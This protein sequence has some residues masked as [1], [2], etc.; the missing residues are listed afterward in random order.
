ML[1]KSIFKKSN[2]VVS[3]S[4]SQALG[5][6][7]LEQRVLLSSVQ[8]FATGETGDEVFQLKVAGEVVG[9]YEIGIYEVFDYQS[10]EAISADDVEVVFIN[11]SWDEATGYDRNLFV[12]KIR[13]DGVSYETENPSVYSTGYIDN[14]VLLD[15]GYLETETLNVNGAFTYSAAGATSRDFGTKI[16]V[17]VLGQEGGEHFHLY[18]DGIEVGQYN[19]T[20]YQTDYY[21][22]SPEEVSIEQIQ[23]EFMN[24]L[25]DPENGID[26]NLTVL[27]VQ[28]TDYATGEST[29]YFADDLYVFSTGV[30]LEGSGITPGFGLGNTLHA[31]GIFD[32]G[33]SLPVI[34]DPSETP[35]TGSSTTD[36]VE[37]TV[38]VESQ[39]TAESTEEGNSE[40]PTLANSQIL[41]ETL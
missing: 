24:D 30:Y 35:E 15:P 25:Y 3:R 40:L 1:R 19:A 4:N 6:E 7:S 5:V 2:E 39:T 17:D 22:N 32:F 38:V 14:G 9:E 41:I 37:T 36:T 20:N 23:I 21:Y 8:V 10:T 13:I 31:N 27:R 34:E 18:I 16:R 11:D 29:D 12:D 33:Y 26:R 28:L